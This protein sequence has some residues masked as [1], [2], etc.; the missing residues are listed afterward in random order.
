MRFLTRSA[1][2]LAVCLATW[3][4]IHSTK[5]VAPAKAQDVA[6]DGDPQVT[7]GTGNYEDTDVYKNSSPSNDYTAT[8]STEDTQQTPDQPTDSTTATATTTQSMSRSRRPGRSPSAAPVKA[9][10]AA[11][12]NPVPAASAEISG[13]AINE[14][15]GM[16]LVEGKANVHDLRPA[17][18]YVWRLRVY[19]A[20]YQPIAT[21]VYAAQSFGTK[22]KRV[23]PTFQDVIPQFPGKT[24]VVL[25]LYMVPQDEALDIL[26]DDRAAEGYMVARR[27]Q[28]L[29]RD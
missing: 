29:R 4:A 27:H 1:A 9:P 13:F 18:R 28:E 8:T 10:N 22:G 14:D 3:M 21:E 17:S 2:F 25:T 5:T 26:Q 11:A 20:A 15:H 24:H 23:S 7:V 19:D 12:A 6:D 16:N